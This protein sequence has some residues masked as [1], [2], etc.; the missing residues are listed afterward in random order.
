[1]NEKLKSELH[2]LNF[3]NGTTYGVTYV[4]LQSTKKT[5][6]QKK[7]APTTNAFTC[8]RTDG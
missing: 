8:V 2:T 7:L 4:Q 5:K 3:V 6:K 1:M